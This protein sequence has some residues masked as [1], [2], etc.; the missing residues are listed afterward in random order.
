MSG[1]Y[2]P[3]CDPPRANHAWDL[4]D[5]CRHC[6][7]AKVSGLERSREWHARHKS[8]R[9]SF[10]FARSVKARLWSSPNVV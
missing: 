9:P 4:S 10:N 2:Q 5:V 6:G 7:R 1:R 3:N 8:G